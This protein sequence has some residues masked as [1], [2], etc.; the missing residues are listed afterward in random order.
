MKTVDVSSLLDEGHWSGYQK[1]LIFATALTIVLDG[2]DNQLLS[3]AIPPMM[4]EWAIASRAEFT[5]VVA[6]GMIGMMLGGAIGGIVGD[7]LGRRVALLTSVFTFGVLTSLIVFVDNLWLLG[8]TRFVAG[9]GLGGAMPNAAALASEYVPRRHRAFAVTLTTVCIPFGGFVA[10]LVGARV[11]PVWGW[12]ALFA[13]GGALPLVLGVILIFALP[14]SPR[15]MVGRRERWNDLRALLQRL[16]HV[17]SP[18][19][20]F[21]DTAERVQK[22][23]TAAV[24]TPEYRRDTLALCASFF[25]CL[26]AAYA[27]VL[28]IPS[29]LAGV[30]FNPAQ[31]SNG[32]AAWNLG[33]VVGALIGAGIITAMGSRTTM[34][35]MCMGAVAGAL[36]IRE[37]IVAP[38]LL[39]FAL[40]AWTGGLINGVQTVMYA[41]AAH[42]YPAP[43]RSTGVGTAVAFGRLG[44][45]VS[46]YA[47]LS[48]SLSS[49][50]GLL[51]MM[52]A[53]VAAALAVV[54][55]HI[56]RNLSGG[57][58]QAVKAA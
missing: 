39:T 30:G 27:S 41:L 2:V 36:V 24:F 40:L 14:E 42:V 54:K 45:V 3:V 8:A 25:F 1:R 33:G 26:M 31:S 37:T 21:A 48:P 29:M 49:L 11:L 19:A 38:T 46:A 23:S 6:A 13:V 17:V 22:A 10:G 12:R 15:F 58:P 18:D 56:G 44:S 20:V 35:G 5:H 51:A 32:L 34:I 53:V 7:R 47:G 57:S 55:R 28:W 50:F 43:I 4:K 16:G 52:M 9:L